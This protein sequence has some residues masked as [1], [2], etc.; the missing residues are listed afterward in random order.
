MTEAPSVAAH[1]YSIQELQRKAIDMRL[2]N[3]EEVEIAG[4]GHYGPSFSCMDILISLYYGY[5]RLLPHEPTWPPRDRFVMG[6]GHAISALYPILADLGFF[7][8]S[9]LATFT[10]LGSNLGDH[11]DMKK[12]AG[13]DF[14][15]GSL[16]HALSIGTGMADGL[17]L[18]G[19][20]SRVVIMLGD[21]ELNE[22]QIWEAAGYAAHHRQ[23]NLLAIVDVNRVTVDGFTVDLLDSEPIEARFAAFGWETERVNGHDLAALRAAL[24]R[25]DARRRDPSARPTAIIADTV[26]GKGIDFIEGMAEWHVGYL[27]GIDKER[28]IKSIHAMFNPPESMDS[29]NRPSE[30]S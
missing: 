28:A 26:A 17:R 14:S 10:Q 23:G 29:A 1:Q 6:K 27:G 19:Y 16:G 13:A 8:H 30:K 20:D 7:P 11:P 22:G 5:L 15:S 4:S 25:F 18:S 24:D 2:A 21:G 9:D 12:V 3:L